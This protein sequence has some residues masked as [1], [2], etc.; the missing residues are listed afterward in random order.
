MKIRL[1]HGIPIAMVR[2]LPCPDEEGHGLK[3]REVEQFEDG[4]YPQ[5]RQRS[6][7]KAARYLI[8]KCLSQVITWNSHIIIERQKMAV[9]VDS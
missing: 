7:V 3:C 1:E 6:A 4:G 5:S 8:Y 9:P 2:G